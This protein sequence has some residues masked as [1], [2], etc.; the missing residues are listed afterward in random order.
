M[1]ITTNTELGL[2]LMP[3]TKKKKK[4]GAEMA[5]SGMKKEGGGGRNWNIF[6]DQKRK[7]LSFKKREE[8][9]LGLKGLCF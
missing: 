4:G 3:C 2:V 7:R 1:R 6:C 8:K 5:V 9:T